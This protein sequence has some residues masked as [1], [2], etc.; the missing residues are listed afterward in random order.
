MQESLPKQHSRLTKQY[1]DLMSISMGIKYAVTV[2]EQGAGVWTVT[3]NFD[4]HEQTQPMTTSRGD[5]KVWRNLVGAISFVQENCK[6]ASD[7]FIEVGGWRLCRVPSKGATE[8]VG[9]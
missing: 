3:V 1:L 9:A 8:P 4:G 5:V 7:V 2:H 6:T